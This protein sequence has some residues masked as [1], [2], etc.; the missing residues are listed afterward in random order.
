MSNKN[1]VN[2]LAYIDAA[3]TYLYYLKYSTGKLS[4]EKSKIYRNTLLARSKIEKTSDLSLPPISTQTR[5]DLSHHSL[6]FSTSSGF[7]HSRYFQEP[8]NR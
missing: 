8:V 6:R 4:E 2:I 3:S 5:P 1:K 7:A